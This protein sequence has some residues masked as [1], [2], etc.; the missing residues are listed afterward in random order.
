MYIIDSTYPRR[1]IRIDLETTH[2]IKDKTLTISKYVS[3]S[4]ANLSTHLRS[5]PIKAR[6][7][8]G[9]PFTP[10]KPAC[11]LATHQDKKKPSVMM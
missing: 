2:S 4:V 9:A 8:K 1:R 3:Q 7:N 11:I 10:L 5:S 6:V